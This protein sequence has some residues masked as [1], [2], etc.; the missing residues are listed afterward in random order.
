MFVK[1]PLLERDLYIVLGGDIRIRPSAACF[2]SAKPPIFIE[3]QC[4][5]FRF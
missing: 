3:K 2:L 5:A 1:C 4:Q